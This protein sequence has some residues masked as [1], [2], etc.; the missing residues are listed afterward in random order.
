AER[1]AY[2]NCAMDR[3]S[4][5]QALLCGKEPY[6][7]RD[8]ITGEEVELSEDDFTDLSKIHLY[9]WLEQAPRSDKRD[10]RHEAYRRL[11][12]RLGGVA[13]ESYGRVF[14]AETVVS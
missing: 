12:S 14:A 9:D 5:D 13:L 4:F 10:Y 8:R 3:A 2:L 6:R 1:L 7:F 11:A